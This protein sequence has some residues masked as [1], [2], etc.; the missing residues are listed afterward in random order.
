MQQVIE[1]LRQ[2]TLVWEIVKLVFVSVAACILVALALKVERKVYRRLMAKKNNINLRFVE[3]I[4]RFLVIFLAAQAVIM[5]SPLT[6]SFGKTLF[7]GTTVI[8][9]IAGFA[10]QPVISDLICGLMISATRPFNIGDRIELDNGVAGVVKDITLRHVVIHK[11]DTIEIV[12]PNSKLNGMVITNMSYETT[13]RS[14]HCKFNVA[15]PTDADRAMAV[16]AHAIE[17]CPYTEPGLP[18]D[19]TLIYAPVYFMAYADSSLVMETTVY[20]QPMTPTEVV[21]SDVNT[22]VK[23]ALDAADIEIPYQ[24]VNV[25]VNEKDS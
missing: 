2:H 7:Q 15:Y 10:A 24:Y 22:R 20:Y 6:E 23:R 4:I 21:K 17:E 18:R 3:N 9:A 16:I 1:F 8:A 13:R 5:S 19:G 25:V 12:V 14:F 11:V